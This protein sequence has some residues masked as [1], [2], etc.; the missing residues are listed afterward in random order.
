MRDATPPGTGL[1]S[2]RAVHAA[3]QVSLLAK[4]AFAVLE[5]VGGVAVYLVPQAVVLRL[6]ERIVRG[7]LLEERRD[8]IAN[9]LLQWAQ[10][11]SISTRHFTAVYLLAH[12]AIKLWLIIGLLRGKMSYYPIAIAVFGVF[13]AYQLYRFHFTHS[14]WLIVITVID[15][16]VIC[17]TACEYRN[18]REAR[19]GLR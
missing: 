2:E 6:V 12:G 1:G 14:I 10:G 8:L 19:R 11:F 3:F 17:L 4:A 13:I 16:V 15:A 5:V 18:L 9:Y 7:E